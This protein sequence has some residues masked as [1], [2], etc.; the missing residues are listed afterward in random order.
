MSSDK[1]QD[2]IHSIRRHI[3]ELAE[4]AGYTGSWS[5]ESGDLKDRL[6]CWIDGLEQTVPSDF[7]KIHE[8]YRRENDAE[9]KQY[10][11]LKKKFAND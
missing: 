5:S 10:L 11:R 1:F 9:Y 8:K 3:D 2:V 4:N 6:E 7:K